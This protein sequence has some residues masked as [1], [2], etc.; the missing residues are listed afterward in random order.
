M[1]VGGFSVGFLS[2]QVFVLHAERFRGKSFHREHDLILVVIPFRL[3]IDMSRQ[4]VWLG[5]MSTSS[6]GERVVESGQTEGP[7][8]LR[9]IQ[10]LGHSEV[11]EVSVVI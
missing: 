2:G 6:M 10:H 5:Q 11:H 7:L 1:D 9:V 3:V 4:G 8:G